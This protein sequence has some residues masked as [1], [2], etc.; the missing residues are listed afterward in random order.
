MNAALL[1]VQDQKLI[2][3]IIIA[4]G[5]ATSLERGKQYFLRR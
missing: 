4:Q 1:S 3:Y 5:Q 2:L